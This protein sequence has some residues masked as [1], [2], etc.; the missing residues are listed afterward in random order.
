MKSYLNVKI[1]FNV[2]GGTDIGMGH[3]YRSLSVAHEI[4]D[5]NIVLFQIK[6]IN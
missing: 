4:T 3:I 6:T 1:I 2:I 5:H